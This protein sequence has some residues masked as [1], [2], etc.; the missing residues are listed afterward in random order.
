MRCG[1]TTVSHK[2]LIK[3]KADNFSENN[4]RHFDLIYWYVFVHACGGH[5][6]D[7]HDLRCQ[8]KKHVIRNLHGKYWTEG[9]GKKRG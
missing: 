8:Y 5:S 6:G 4:L 9:E 1:A 2:T 7:D 3:V